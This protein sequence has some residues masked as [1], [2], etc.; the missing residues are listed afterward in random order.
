[1]RRIALATVLT[2]AAGLTSVLPAQSASAIDPPQ[3][4]TVRRLAHA[5]AQICKDAPDG[6]IEIKYRLRA[7]RATA[8]V[9]IRG[10][11]AVKW[12]SGWHTNDPEPWSKYF[13]SNT[14]GGLSWADA[15]DMKIRIRLRT[16]SHTADWSVWHDWHDIHLCP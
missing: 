2:L 12:S 1:M 16:P 8:Q 7:R 13:H 14:Y 6:G 15:S 11:T 5:K 10:Q 9:A 4:D 3:W